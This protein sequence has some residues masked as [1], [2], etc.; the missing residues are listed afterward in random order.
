MRDRPLAILRFIVTAV[1]VVALINDFL[2]T[3]IPRCVIAYEF[4]SLQIMV[5]QA[6]IL[7]SV[8]MAAP[9]PFAMI[10]FFHY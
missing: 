3:T 4:T 5:V 10:V 6:A 8:F 9:G 1:V 7:S 2:S